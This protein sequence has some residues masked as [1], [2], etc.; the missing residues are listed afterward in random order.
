[1]YIYFQ[2]SPPRFPG[3]NM[4]IK[5]EQTPIISSLEYHSPVRMA[6]VLTHIQA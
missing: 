3:A 2:F 6:G 1:M 4:N 5:G